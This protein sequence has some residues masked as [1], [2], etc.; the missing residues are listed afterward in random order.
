MNLLKLFLTT[1]LAAA[2]L[3]GCRRSK[4]SEALMGSPFKILVINCGST[5]FKLR[6][7]DMDDETLLAKGSIDNIG[8]E[9]H[10]SMTPQNSRDAIEKDCSVK[11]HSEALKVLLDLLVSDEL[12]I[13][14]SLSEIKAV[15]HRVVH[16]GERFTDSVLIDEDVM[17]AIEECSALAPLHNPAAIAGIKACQE[18]ISE[19]PQV[20]AFDTAFHGTMPEKA[21]MYAIPYEYYSDYK[22][23][24]YG[25]HGISHRYVTE[26]AAKL[27]GKPLEDLK[28]IS[29]HLGGGSSVCAVSGGKSVDTT[30]GFTPA[31]G[32]PMGSRSG[33]L[34]PAMLEYLYKNTSKD[35]SEITSIFNEES[36]MLGISNVSSDYRLVNEAAQ[37]GNERAALSLDMYHYAVAKAIGAYAAAMNGVDGIIFTAGIGENSDSAREAICSYLTYLGVKLKKHQ[38]GHYSEGTLISTSRS[39]VPV[40]VIPTNEELVIARDTLSIVK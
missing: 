27:L 17:D 7:Y 33:D 19:V 14:D 25:F 40:M 23:R 11:C 30:M 12:G 1:T 29:C 20:A 2:L 8:G 26:Q 4:P 28:L 34:D 5:S 22:I 24:R 16:G 32:V 39:R 35:V 21:F 38:E 3:V 9:G 10:L 37:A 15:G 6:L 18:L 13:L 36:G 31:S